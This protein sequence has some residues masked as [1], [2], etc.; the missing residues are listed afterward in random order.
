MISSTKKELESE[1]F[2]LQQEVNVL[3]TNLA[4]QMQANVQVPVFF[5]NKALSKLFKTYASMH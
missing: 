4:A 2:C 3:K 5:L 1:N